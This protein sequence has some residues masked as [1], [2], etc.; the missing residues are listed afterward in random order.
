MDGS[1][2]H[3][4]KALIEEEADL[5][6]EGLKNALL[7]HYEGV[8]DGNIFEQLSSLQQEGNI[9]ERVY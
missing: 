6:W 5:T 8:S 3:F 4:F 1:T 9:I 2:I 7:E